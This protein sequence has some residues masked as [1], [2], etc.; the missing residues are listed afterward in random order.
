M[1][2]EY[3]Q[4]NMDRGGHDKAHDRTL[5]VKRANLI[6]NDKECL[7]LNFSDITVMKLLKQE[8]QKTK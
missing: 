7:V 3:S 4:E 6:F 5:V 2:N 8:E 1:L